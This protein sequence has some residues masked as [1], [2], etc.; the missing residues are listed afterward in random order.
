MTEIKENLVDLN[1]ILQ[2]AE[3][4]KETEITTVGDGFDVEFYPLFSSD[5]VDNLIKTAGEIVNSDEKE[6]QPFI[7]LIESSDEDYMLFIHFLMVKEFTHLG[8]DMKDKKPSELFAYYEALIKTGYLTELVE[9]VFLPDQVRK[10]IKRVAGISAL[11]V[12]MMNLS[13]DFADSMEEH[14][15]KIENIQNV[16]NQAQDFQDKKK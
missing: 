7:E 2:E 16:R 4:Y 13:A 5:K 1:H 11:G 15:G 6:G 8:E 3:R 9:D 14:K 10:V 12:N